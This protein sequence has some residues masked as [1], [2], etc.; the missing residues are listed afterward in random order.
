[1]SF[2]PIRSREF[3]EGLAYYNQD[4]DKLSL[5]DVGLFSGALKVPKRAARS[6]ACVMLTP[7]HPAIEQGFS[8]GRPLAQQL[9]RGILHGG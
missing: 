9:A 4:A 7:R 1:M 5:I 2:S 6:H 3:E 8:I